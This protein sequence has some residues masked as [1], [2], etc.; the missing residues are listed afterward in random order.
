MPK[1]YDVILLDMDGTIAYTDEM[2]LRTFHTLY[3]LYNPSAR[4]PDEE[5]IYFSGPP[6]SITLPREFPNQDYQFMHDEFIRISTP[7]YEECV[8]LYE[9][10]LKVLSRL[11]NAGY[12]LGVVTNKNH[13]MAAYVLKL[14]NLDNLIDYLVGGGDTLQSKPDPEGIYLAMDKLGGVKEKTLYVG[15]NDI[16]FYTADHA[17]V[18]SMICTWGPRTLTVLDKC[19]YKVNSYKEIEDTLL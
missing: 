1:K 3:D 14:L 7:L 16:D 15:D 17:G 5:I 4:K 10:E 11:K 2:L 9:D 12:K 13:K 18:D 8:T 19:T 6:L